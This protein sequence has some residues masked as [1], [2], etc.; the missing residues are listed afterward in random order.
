MTTLPQAR[1]RRERSAARGAHPLPDEW[2]WR[3]SG[4]GEGQPGSGPRAA[5]QSAVRRHVTLTAERT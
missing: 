5:R 1:P 2:G 3:G 4:M